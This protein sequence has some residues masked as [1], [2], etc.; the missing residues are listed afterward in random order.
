M[1]LTQ[2]PA[3]PW[4]TQATA[5]E[6]FPMT[7]IHFLALDTSVA[8]PW[9]AVARQARTWAEA[10]QIELRDAVLLLPLAAH[11]NLARIAWA[12]LGGWMPR[13]ETTLS[14]AR[15]LPS[16]PG[17]TA[18]P[19]QI[20]FDVAT[21]RLQAAR[22]LRAQSWATAG[23]HSDPRAFALATAKMVETAHALARAAAGVE[24]SQR[25]AYWE[26]ARALFGLSGAS[27]PGVQER[28]LCRVAL[29]WAAAAADPPTDRLFDLR[30]SAWLTVQ[31]GGSDDFTHQ[32]MASAPVPAL[33]LDADTAPAALRFKPT[34]SVAVCADFE[35]EAQRAAAAVIAQLNL[36]HLPVAL[37][38]QD[39]ALVRRI[40]ALLDR[41]NIPMRDETGWKLS[42]TRAAASVHG[43]LDCANHDAS[44]D[45]LL[46]L[47]KATPAEPA[48]LDALE[49]SWR[50]SGVKQARSGQP[51][52]LDPVPRDLLQ[53]S[54]QALSPLTERPVRPLSAWLNALQSALQNT[55][56]WPSLMADDAGQQVLSRLGLQAL[57]SEGAPSLPTDAL[58]L[59]AFTE[60]VEASLESSS[61]IPPSHA[62]APVVITPLNQAMLRPFA[63]VVFPGADSAHLSVGAGRAHARGPTRSASRCLRAN[64]H[65]GRTPFFATRRRRR[66]PFDDQPLAGSVGAAS[67]SRRSLL[68]GRDRRAQQLRARRRTGRT[69]HASSA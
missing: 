20:C 59:Q 1:I 5:H 35:E 65:S 51:D 22:M 27:G 68:D 14:L 54:L 55:G 57:E 42:T 25:A 36:G 39:R 45:A 43:L 47:L 6:N 23:L 12:R 66:R 10:Q 24:P 44:S 53:R 58:S 63:A 16:L 34:H 32:L 7:A 8:D 50:K 37:I 30:P 64:L 52:A 38:A 41:Q 13:I 33:C 26:Q 69:P 2:R 62:D 28:L 19:G 21:D 61:F 46:D 67:R 60:W 3:P 29:E 31:A 11:L 15:S 40:R 49:P 56:M 17:Q 18:M 9:Q 48:A 4:N